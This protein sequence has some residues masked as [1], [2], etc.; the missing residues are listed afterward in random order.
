MVL[1]TCKGLSKTFPN[2]KHLKVSLL[3]WTLASYILLLHLHK[4]LETIT[5]IL[6]MDS[7]YAFALATPG[8]RISDRKYHLCGKLVG[9]FEK[10]AGLSISK[11]WLNVKCINVETRSKESDIMFVDNVSY[12]A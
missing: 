1:L 3:Y 10:Y 7:A 4:L 9:F 6:E 5:I 8:K 12:I 11:G 2:L